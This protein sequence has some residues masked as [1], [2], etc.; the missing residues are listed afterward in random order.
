VR[1]KGIIMLKNKKSTTNEQIKIWQ[2]RNFFGCH[3]TASKKLNI[4]FL[5]E[6]SHYANFHIKIREGRVEKC[7]F[8]HQITWL[9][10]HMNQ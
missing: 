10:S 8:I 9:E 7:H 6:N 1:W 2:P 4:W 5:V 3:L